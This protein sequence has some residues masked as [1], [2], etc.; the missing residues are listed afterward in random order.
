[1][2][3]P[4]LPQLLLLLL[5]PTLLIGLQLQHRQACSN[6]NSSSSS[7]GVSSLLHLV[8]RQLP[9]LAATQRLAATQTGRQ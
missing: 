7:K 9:L 2:F 6:G 4:V 8:L 5:L 3:Q 1:V